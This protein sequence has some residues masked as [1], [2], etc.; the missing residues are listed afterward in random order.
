MVFELRPEFAGRLLQCPRCGR[1]LRA[2]RTPALTREARPGLDPAFDR[3][4]FLLN[5]RVLTIASQYEVWA[6]DGTPVLYVIPGRN[7]NR[8]VVPPSTSSQRS[9]GWI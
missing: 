2:G 7:Q 8:Y 4:V 1:R 9:V 3:D 5:Q 6:P